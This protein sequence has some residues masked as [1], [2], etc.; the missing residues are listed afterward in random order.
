MRTSQNGQGRGEAVRMTSKLPLILQVSS[1]LRNNPELTPDSTLVTRVLSLATRK[2]RRVTSTSSC[3]IPVDPYRKISEKR[4]S[5]ICDPIHLIAPQLLRPRP[6]PNCLWEFLGELHKWI[7]SLD[8]TRH[9]RNYYAL[10]ALDT[11]SVDHHHLTSLYRSL[12]HTPMGT[13]RSLPLQS[14]SKTMRTLFLSITK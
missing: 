4:V 9:P 10:L 2:P 3:S 8:Q 11:P 12:H 1:T 7:V 5:N 6:L 14:P 13:Q